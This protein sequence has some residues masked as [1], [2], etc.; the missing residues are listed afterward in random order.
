[1]AAIAITSSTAGP[2]L[3]GPSWL[4][5]IMECFVVIGGFLIFAGAVN[6]SM[7]GSN[8]VMNRLAEDGV[9][10]PGSCTRRNATEQPTASSTSSA[11]FN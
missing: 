4:K 5:I 9:L 11:F 6:T 1:M 2:N 7:I 10:T 8:G 3:A